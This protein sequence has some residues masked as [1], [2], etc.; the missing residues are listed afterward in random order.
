[1]GGREGR[2]GLNSSIT[3]WIKLT[4]NFSPHWSPVF[5]V[6][7]LHTSGL[8]NPQGRQCRYAHSP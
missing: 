7:I 2:G 4:H 5:P 6:Q 8:Q 1:M 3:F